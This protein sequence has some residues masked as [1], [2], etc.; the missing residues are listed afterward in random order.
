MLKAAAELQLELLREALESGLTIKDSTPYNIQF[1]G[2]VPVFVDIGSFAS[3]EQGEPWLGYRQ[4]CRQ[5]LYPLLIRSHADIS[6]LPLLLWPEVRRRHVEITVRRAV[7]AVD[8][9]KPVP[10]CSEARRRSAGCR[11]GNP[12]SDEFGRHHGLRGS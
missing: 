5:F 10:F 3:Y 9:R 8:Q 7:I 12:V 2:T 4:F 6:Y 11:G 1:R